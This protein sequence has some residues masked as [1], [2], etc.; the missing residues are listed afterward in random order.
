MLL[1]N[2]LS[3][4][5]ITASSL[6]SLNV[7]AQDQ[8]TSAEMEEVLILGAS[9]SYANNL[10]SDS[11]KNLE[12]DMTSV[13]AVI[14]LVPG[15]LI[16]EGD[17]FGS[18]D[19]STTVSMRGFQL[20]LDEQQIGMTVDGVPNGNSNYGGGS[21][22]NRFIDTPNLDTV[23]V[24]QGTADISSRSHEALGGTLNFTTQ[25]PTEEARL[26]FST[27]QGDHN[28]QKTYA[29][30][31]TGTIFGNTRAWMSVSSM[32][33]DAWIDES[34]ESIRDHAAVKWISDFE[35]FSMTG[36]IAYDDVE[37]DKMYR[38]GWST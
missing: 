34:G 25:D 22:A 12:S 16:N 14:D 19:W 11:M 2:A 32:N 1:R 23:E 13:L 24:S 18:D 35:L 29:R 15:V 17:V 28:A 20:S 37:E 33:T 36:Y 31:D 6:S 4:A 7:Y 38:R 3:L 26:R 21:K 5:V 9:T 8:N 10:V 30:Y 27:I